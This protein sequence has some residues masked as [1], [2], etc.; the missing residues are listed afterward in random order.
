MTSALLESTWTA[1]RGECPF[2]DRW[3]ATDAY[4]SEL[5]VTE[6]VRAYVRALQPDFVIETGTCRGNTAQAIGEALA[7]NGQGELVTLEIA[8]EAAEEARRRCDGLPVR[9]LHQSSLEYTPERQIDFAWF[10]SE[11]E[12]RPLEFRRYL[13]WMHSRTIVG[14][15]DTGSQHGLRPLLRSLQYEGL[16]LGVLDLPTPRGACFARVKAG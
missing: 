5:E 3:H 10:D 2:P 12:M 15:H 4:S 7:L 1:P 14:F 9:V 13:P 16:L 6:L 8:E 11:V